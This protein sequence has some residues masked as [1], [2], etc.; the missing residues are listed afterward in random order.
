MYTNNKKWLLLVIAFIISTSVYSQYRRGYSNVPFDLPAGLSLTASFGP[1]VF[2]GDLV[3]KGRFGH[4]FSLRLDR[5]MSQLISA[6]AQLIGGNMQ[7]TQIHP[8]PISISPGEP[9]TSGHAYAEFDNLYVEFSL[10]ATYR[11]LNHF[12]GYFKERT[13]QLYAL[14][15]V[16]AVYYNADEY[17]R[18]ASSMT[19]GSDPGNKWR[20]ATG[21]A[22]TVGAGGG[23]S[24]WIT[25]KLS[26]NVEF[27]GTLAFS[28]KL[29]AHDVWYSSYPDGEVYDTDPFD[30]YYTATF[31]VTYLFKDSPFSNEPRFNRKSYTKTR[32]FFQPKTRSK[33]IRPGRHTK[34]R[35]LFF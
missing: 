20:N 11:P 12:L 8:L 15:Q 4:S 13:A 28:D 17:W 9:A 16:G 33:S 5:E 19:P 35:W 24:F 18:P 30:F 29:D 34:R 25:P 26:A 32:K 31:G 3:N 22:P 23:V 14:A 27:V 1:N 2:Y 10:G 6:R 7:G 21:V